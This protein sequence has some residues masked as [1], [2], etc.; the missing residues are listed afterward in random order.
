[1]RRVTLTVEAYIGDDQLF[2]PRVAKALR[3]YAKAIEIGRCGYAATE[4]FV[5]TDNT[6]IT[7]EAG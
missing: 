5:T 4:I 7:V 6:Y 1:M 2:S 3:E